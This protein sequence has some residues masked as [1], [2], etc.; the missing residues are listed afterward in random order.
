MLDPRRGRPV[1][2]P[3]SDEPPTLTR[4]ANLIGG[5]IFPGIRTGF[6]SGPAPKQ[7]ADIV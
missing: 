5:Y 3:P 4:G 6:A 2:T 1:S 7:A